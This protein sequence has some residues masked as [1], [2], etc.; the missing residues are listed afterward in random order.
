M[1]GGAAAAGGV[2]S[3]HSAAMTKTNGVVGGG[4]REA[5]VAVGRA[6]PRTRSRCWGSS[7]L[8]LH[9]PALGP[10]EGSGGAHGVNGGAAQRPQR[11]WRVVV[12]VGKSPVFATGSPAADVAEVEERARRAGRGRRRASRRRPPRSRRSRSTKTAAGPVMCGH[13]QKLLPR[14]Q[15]A[16]WSSRLGTARRWVVK[17]G[18][19]A[20]RCIVTRCGSVSGPTLARVF[21]PNDKRPAPL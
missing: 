5:G 21:R 7:W 10:A 16:G 4:V 2:V 20:M 1:R 11:W 18:R 6:P 12:G 19:R 13:H 9:G 15:A 3:D 17:R 8:R 14:R